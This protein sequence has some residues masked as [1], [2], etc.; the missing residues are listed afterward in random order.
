MLTPSE[1]KMD[2]RI[3]TDCCSSKTT[4]TADNN[5]NKLIIIITARK[6]ISPKK[7]QHGKIITS[8]H[9]CTETISRVGHK[10]HGGA[11]ESVHYSTTD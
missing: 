2:L 8:V 11:M 3:S 7:E 1:H 10:S 5:S 6:I 4:N 9:R